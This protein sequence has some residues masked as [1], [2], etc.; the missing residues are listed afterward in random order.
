[1][2]VVDSSVTQ[3]PPSRTISGFN[4]H[5]GCHVSDVAVAGLRSPASATGRQP[6][7]SGSV[8]AVNGVHA[9][10]VTAFHA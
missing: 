8:M 7:S 9:P 4:G 10:T 6:A 3:L 5:A 2:S 1:M